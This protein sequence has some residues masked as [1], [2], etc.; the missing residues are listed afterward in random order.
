VFQ[1]H[2]RHTNRAGGHGWSLDRGC[3]LRCLRGFC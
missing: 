2:E 3:H 1:V